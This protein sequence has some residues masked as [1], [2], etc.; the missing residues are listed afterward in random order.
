MSE[1]E[2]RPRRKIDNYSSIKKEIQSESPNTVKN[3]TQFKK[4]T[5]ETENISTDKQNIMNL[6][7]DNFNND[8]NTGIQE[9]QQVTNQ[10]NKQKVVNNNTTSKNQETTVEDN[11]S[12]ISFEDINENQH[13]WHEA[14]GAKKYKIW[15]EETE[16][17]MV[18]SKVFNKQRMISVFFDNEEKMNIVKKINIGAN[19]TQP[20]YIHRA[21]IFKRNPQRDI[22]HDIK[23]WDI[24]ICMKYKELVFEISFT[25]EDIERMNLRTNNIVMPLNFTTEML[26]SRGEFTAKVI[27]LPIGFIVK[28]LM[29][30]IEKVETETCYFPRTRTYR[31]KEET[32]VSFVLHCNGLSLNTSWNNENTT[33]T[34][35]IIDFTTKTCHKCY[36]IEHLISNCPLTKQTP[37]LKKRK[38][39]VLKI[40]ANITK[41]NRF[42]KSA[43]IG[44]ANDRLS[45][46][47]S[48]LLKVSERLTAL[49][50]HIWNKT[51]A[52][53]EQDLFDLND[54]VD[55]D[56]DSI[57]QENSIYLPI[58]VEVCRMIE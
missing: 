4:T 19:A 44:D 15:T 6:E 35:K 13:E 21:V 1:Q 37:S 43:P 58:I 10:K 24:S 40:Y 12:I 5:W 48:L 3:N 38:S 41:K 27:G 30:T 25:F 18:T 29:P 52:D 50:G 57:E 47:E 2:D 34:I 7:E 26:K 16:L 20:S 11:E 46:I 45:H 42:N 22:M 54:N 36:S 32:I 33:T 39:I 28:E 17:I 56:E 8:S 49:E 51:N 9:W 53:F 23:L 14:F 31:C 55:M